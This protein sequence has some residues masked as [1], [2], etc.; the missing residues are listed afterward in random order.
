MATEI[1][2]IYQIVLIILVSVYLFAFGIKR[3]IRRRLVLGGIF[4]ILIGVWFLIMQFIWGVNKTTL[5]L[6]I[7]FILLGVGLFI[8]FK[9]FWRGNIRKSEGENKTKN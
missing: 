3:T 6:G 9:F 5:V 4:Y 8:L 1:P 2:L 7:I